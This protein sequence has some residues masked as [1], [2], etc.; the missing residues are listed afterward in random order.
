[1]V[2][3]TSDF[4]NGRLRKDLPSNLAIESCSTS[5]V[6]LWRWIVK[7][8]SCFW[9]YGY[10]DPR[11]GRVGFWD[12][13]WVRGVRVRGLFHRV[14]A[15]AATHNLLLFDFAPACFRADWVLPLRVDLR[16][17]AREE[18]RS[19]L[20]F[21]RQLSHESIL[22]GPPVF[23]LA[24]YE[25]GFVFDQF[26]TFHLW[27]V[28]VNSC[29]PDLGLERAELDAQASRARMLYRCVL[30]VV[31]WLKVSSAIAIQDVEMWIRH[32]LAP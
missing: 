28:A 12:D 4:W 8:S 3:V 30:A 10:V 2:V 22:K 24:P 1:M 27:S 13:Y 32:L 5:R 6:S 26:K 14:A 18:F 23:D 17:G 9:D 7:A 21:L 29:G 25:F 20:L 31:S 15:A 11:G 16:G 19:F